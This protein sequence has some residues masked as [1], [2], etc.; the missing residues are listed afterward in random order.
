MNH[1]YSII[2]SLR[3]TIPAVVWL[4]ILTGL[5]GCTAI[6]VISQTGA[7]EYA[8]T[9]RAE[10]FASRGQ[11]RE[12]A[13]AYLELANLTADYAERQSYLIL[14]AHERLLAGFPEI[15]KNI[16]NRLGEPIAESNLLLRSRVMAEIYI[17]TDEPKRALETLA[18]A[19]ASQDQEMMLEILRLQG[20]AL[21]RTGQPVAATEILIERETWLEDSNDIL[22]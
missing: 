20:N 6:P 7:P 18:R 5:A 2:A 19:P 8:A 13:D 21:F 16:L 12:A 11:H 22:T 17:A 15:A 3:L 10:Q 14:M 1:Q 9:S 4:I